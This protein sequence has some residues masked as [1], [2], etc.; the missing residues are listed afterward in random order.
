VRVL[1]AASP[2]AWLG[3]RVRVKVRVRVRIRVRV[4]ASL[5]APAVLAAALADRQLDVARVA[6]CIGSW[7]RI[8]V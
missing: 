3:V 6:V 7:V 2:V 1:A 4:R 5:V 8:R